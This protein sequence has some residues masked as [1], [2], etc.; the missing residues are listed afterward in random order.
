MN[1]F[2]LPIVTLSGWGIEPIC[3]R[4]EETLT[5]IIQKESRRD[6]KMFC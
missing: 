5:I 2:K 3:V 4:N 1:Y 6:P